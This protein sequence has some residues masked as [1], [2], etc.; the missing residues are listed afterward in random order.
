MND[1]NIVQKET[2][3]ELVKQ[4]EQVVVIENRVEDVVINADAAKVQIESAQKH[5]KS[6]GKCLCWI[7]I[8]VLILIAAIVTVLLLTNKS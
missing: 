2:A 5:Q 8:A 7:V 4:H 3:T 1:L 6:T